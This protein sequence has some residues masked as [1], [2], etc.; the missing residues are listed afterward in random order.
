MLRKSSNLRVV[1]LFSNVFINTIEISTICWYIFFI[2]SR[3][4]EIWSRNMSPHGDLYRLPLLM[5]CFYCGNLLSIISKNSKLI[6][7]I[8]ATVCT[9]PS[10]LLNKRNIC[11]RLWNCKTCTYWIANFKA[12]TV[13]P[14]TYL[15]PERTKLSAADY[16]SICVTGPRA[17]VHFGSG[18]AEPSNSVLSRCSINVM[19]ATNRRSRPTQFWKLKTF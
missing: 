6:K 8:M 10:C 11:R 18:I 15:N 3:S 17:S 4:Y 16:T 12:F 7:L 14:T 2:E 13:R 5:L 1:A 19:G 9:V